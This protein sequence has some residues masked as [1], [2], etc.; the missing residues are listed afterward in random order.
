MV[1]LPQKKDKDKP[2]STLFKIYPQNRIIP[3]STSK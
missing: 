2:I 1:I 3:P